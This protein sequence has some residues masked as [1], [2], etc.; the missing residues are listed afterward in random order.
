MKK[1]LA[2][3]LRP[4]KI[5]EIIGQ[6]H[7]VGREG[8]VYKMIRKKQLF[9]LI[10]YGPSGTGKTSLANVIVN[11]LDLRY[12]ELNAVINNKK[13][14]DV[15]FEEAK[16]YNGLVLVLDEI[17]RLNKDKQD[18]LLPHI[19]SGLITLIG[20]TSANPFHKIN[21]AIRSRCHLFEFKPLTRNELENGL[22]QIVKNEFPDLKITNEAKRAIVQSANYDMRNVINN[23]EMALL[24]NNKNITLDTIKT[25]ANKPIH[26]SDANEDNY[27]D[28][29][30]AFQ[31]SI[32]GGDVN[33][34]LYY[35]GRLIVVEDL[36]SICRRLTVIV[37]EDIGLAN[38]SLHTRINLGIM[39]CE[40]VGLP[41]AKIILSN[42]VIEAALAPKSNSA[43]L[44]ITEVLN[45]INKGASYSIPKH[46]KNNNPNYKYPH[47][48]EFSYVKQQ[49]LPDQIKKSY[50]IPK[51]NKTEKQYQEILNKL[52]KRNQ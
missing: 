41:E 2:L 20:L 18:I 50:Y 15:V 11:E 28:M 51:N 17:H 10:F 35:L 40:R 6:K 48:Y 29:L 49:Y 36:D 42:L 30:S 45:D 3:K 43:Y 4:K 32:R 19:E 39:A 23:L 27:Y 47:D 38:P 16:M 52:K 24:I 33:A 21:P 9:S 12:R 14:F 7:L 46:L 1:P 8:V 26:L 37:Y 31:K 44:A 25:I 5:A 22:N 13:D 34:S